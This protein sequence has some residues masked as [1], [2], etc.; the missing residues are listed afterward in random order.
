MERRICPAEKHPLLVAFNIVTLC[1]GLVFVFQAIFA[2]TVD[3]LGGMNSDLLLG[4]VCVILGTNTGKLTQNFRHW[5]YGLTL[6]QKLFA[7]LS[8]FIGALVG[9]WVILAMLNFLNP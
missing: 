5:D 8:I 2:E 7:S 9:G 3:M 6:W 4:T 1:V